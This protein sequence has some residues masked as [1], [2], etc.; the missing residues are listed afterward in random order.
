MIFIQILYFR[1][2]RLQEVRT[3][4]K[5]LPTYSMP[6]MDGAWQVLDAPVIKEIDRLTK[7]FYAVGF[8]FLLLIKILISS[9]SCIIHR[10]IQ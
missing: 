3:W 8:F 6:L 4:I 7:S 1:R 5:K 10:N 9:F 2:S